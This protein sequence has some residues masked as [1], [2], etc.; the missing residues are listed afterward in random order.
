M[1][2]CNWLTSGNTEVGVYM[3]NGQANDISLITRNDAA[4]KAGGIAIASVDE[5]H[6]AAFYN[7]D[8][9]LYS[10][11]ANGTDSITTA[12][13]N[14]ANLVGTITD[15]F[16][17]GT[18]SYYGAIDL[19]GNVYEMTDIITENAIYVRGGYFSSGTTALAASYNN[20]TGLTE[21]HPYIEVYSFRVT[22][23]IPE[24]STYAAIFGA[25]ALAFAAYRRKK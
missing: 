14:F 18:E 17:Y 20:I 8:T 7:G 12:E 2:F 5:W 22:S 13:A 11:F 15:V 10:T 9:G 21:D 3:F 23:Y 1:R 6:K 4:W 16:T 24:P 19:N 25:F